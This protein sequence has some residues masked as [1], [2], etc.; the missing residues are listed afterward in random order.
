MSEF[1]IELIDLSWIDAKC[2]SCMFQKDNQCRRFPPSRNLTVKH[3]LT[4]YPVVDESTPACA[5]YLEA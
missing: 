4:D 2:C 5:E 3:G 1:D